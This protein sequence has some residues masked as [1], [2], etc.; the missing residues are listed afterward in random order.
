MA[1]EIKSM[2]QYSE[3]AQQFNNNSGV[4]RTLTKDK[5]QVQHKI[6]SITG[7]FNFSCYG[8]SKPFQVTVSLLNSSGKEIVSFSSNNVK[9]SDATGTEFTFEFNIANLTKKEV[10]SITQIKFTSSTNDK[11]TVDG[12]QTDR[13]IYAK[14]TQ[15]IEIVSAPSG[16]IYYHDG[17]AWR[18]CE[19]YYH[20]GTEWKRAEPYYHDGTN[21]KLCGG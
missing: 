14:G 16:T 11:M 5:T 20:D 7:I 4:T 21:W 17:T 10:D 19:V 18:E 12:V 1:T 3:S 2:W 8:A 9:L 6:I 13:K 15:I